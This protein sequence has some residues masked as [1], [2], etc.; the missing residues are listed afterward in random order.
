MQ[1][2]YAKAKG[3][4]KV[5]NLYVNNAYGED[6]R[7]AIHDAAKAAGLEILLDEAFEAADTNMMAQLTKVKASGAQAVLV[8]AIPPAAAVLTKQYRELGLEMPLIHNH[9]IGMKPF[10]SLSGVENAEGVL[11]PIGK[12]VAADT[13]PDGDPQK[14]VL[15]KFI[16]DYESF[17]GNPAS[18]FAGHAWDAIQI[19]LKALGT[20]PAGLALDEQR[21]RVRTAIE[22]T[23]GFPGT[24]GIFNM[25][26][27]DHV[28]LSTQDVVLVKIE[29]GNWVYFPRDKW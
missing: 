1:V 27:Q 22:S 23:Q 13:L 8:T 11:F 15:L 21:A 28:G 19:T 10:I 29:K 26:A 14:A 17:T 20:L 5:A 25:S 2:E 3:F 9:G 12:M 24:G 6:G 4:T 16:K 7:N 18:T